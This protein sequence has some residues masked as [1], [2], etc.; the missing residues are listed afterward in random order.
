MRMLKTDLVLS[1]EAEE[2]GRKQKALRRIISLNEAD[3]QMT[4]ETI[5]EWSAPVH[6]SVWLS[7]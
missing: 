4:R 5:Q 1:Q 2:I 7:I 6:S 3:R